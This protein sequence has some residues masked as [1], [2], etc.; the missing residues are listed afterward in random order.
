MAQKDVMAIPLAGMATPA[1]DGL[2]I[3]AKERRLVVAAAPGNVIQVTQRPA[4]APRRAIGRHGFRHLNGARA[5]R[6]KSLIHRNIAPLCRCRVV[7]V[8]RRPAGIRHSHAHA[9]V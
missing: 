6:M 4:E 8:T 3:E 7:S 5:P 2:L 9:F 1:R